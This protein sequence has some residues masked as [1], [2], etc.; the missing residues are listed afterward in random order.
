MTLC[1]FKKK[2]IWPSVTLK[3]QNGCPKL[4]KWVLNKEIYNLAIIMVFVYGYLSQQ[5]CCNNWTCPL[6]L[7]WNQF[8]TYNFY[9]HWEITYYALPYVCM[10][11]NFHQFSDWKATI[12]LS[13]DLLRTLLHI[14]CIFRYGIHIKWTR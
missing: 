2:N 6:A 10:W 3:I 4:K 7:I 9:I 5:I 1:F 14:W 13:P 12:W 11:T 8:L